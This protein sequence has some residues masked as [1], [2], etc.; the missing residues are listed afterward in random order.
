MINKSNMEVLFQVTHEHLQSFQVENNYFSST[1]NLEFT[2]RSATA[3]R[4]SSSHPCRVRPVQTSNAS[5]PPTATG[6][7]TET[8]AA[9][10]PLVPKLKN[11]VGGDNKHAL[12]S[13][14]S[15]RREHINK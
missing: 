10:R 13:R 2:S 9:H 15:K 5:D 11:D 4:P 7:R 12:V 6:S 1:Y 8:F 14:N 3:A